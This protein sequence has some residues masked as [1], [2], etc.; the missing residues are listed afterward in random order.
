M[1]WLE[2]GSEWKQKLL[3]PAVKSRLKPLYFS[4]PTRG[5]RRRLGT[6]I[7]LLKMPADGESRLEQMLDR[8]PPASRTVLRA[9]AHDFY[10]ALVEGAGITPLTQLRTCA[11]LADLPGMRNRET[12]LDSRSVAGVG[13]LRLL[14]VTGHFP[15]IEHGGGLRI[16]DLIRTLSSRH[17]ISLYSTYDPA[18]DRHTFD[19]LR[20]FLQ[21]VRLIEGTNAHLSPADFSRWLGARPEFDAAHYVWGRTAPLIA[22]GRSRIERSIFEFNECLTRRWTINLEREV[23]IGIGRQ[24]QDRLGRL[25]TDWIE[26]W[27]ME[28]QAIA[29]S[30]STIAV[31]PV[32]AS[33]ASEVFGGG[34]STVIP[35]C[36]SDSEIWDRLPPDG[37]TDAP[38]GV[39]TFVG[40]YDHPPNLEGM[41]WYLRHIHSVVRSQVPSY[42]L[43]IVGAGD[44]SSLKALVGSDPTVTF[45]GRVDDLVPVIRRASLCISPL[46]SGA[47]IRGKINQYSACGRATVSTSIGVS[48]TPYRDGEEVAIADDPHTFAQRVIELLSDPARGASMAIAA[49]RVARDQFSWS[50]W[51]A[52]LEKLYGG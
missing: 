52:P 22:A 32:D 44:T 1:N 35:T 50:R 17:R 16:Y 7:S 12:G 14:F 23:E 2:L 25:L 21:E 15:A 28:A 45:T 37:E 51:I 29:A 47:G 5:L 48:G 38:G 3:S 4:T 30:D 34:L 49:H 8:L 43:E 36:V 24:N 41:E 42:R 39:V 31:T 19:L 33:F 6:G 18:R 26:V 10:R 27:S 40:F 46:V 11:R 20:P 13:P 9:H